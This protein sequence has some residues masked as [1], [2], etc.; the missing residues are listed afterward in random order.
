MLDEH[1][2]GCEDESKFSE[3]EASVLFFYTQYLYPGN[4]NTGCMINP[5]KGGDDKMHS[6]RVHN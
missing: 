3:P 5:K 6:V 4:F 2:A 1:T